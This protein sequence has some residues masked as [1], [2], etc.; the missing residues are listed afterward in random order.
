[1]LLLPHRGARVSDE[2]TDIFTTAWPL[3]RSRATIDGML[4]NGRSRRFDNR[5]QVQLEAL[6]ETRDTPILPDGL[7]GTID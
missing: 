4:G 6:T 3:G 2:V 7:H 1:M 5:W